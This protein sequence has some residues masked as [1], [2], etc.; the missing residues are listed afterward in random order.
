MSNIIEIW[1]ESL[2]RLL[3]FY[4]TKRGPLM[5]FYPLLFLFFILINLACYWWAMYTAFPELT[6]GG[7][8]QYYAKVQYPVGVLGALFDSLSFFVT[9]FIIRRA[10]NSTKASEYIGHLSI[11]L[12]IA[13]LATF[14]VLFVFTFS[15]WFINYVQATPQSLSG[16]TDRYQQM[17]TD[18]LANP[19][20]NL[21]NIYFG[22]IMGISAMIPTCTHI[23]M[24]LRAVFLQVTGS[25]KQ[26]TDTPLSG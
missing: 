21:R 23:F 26:A 9:I 2:K 20:G 17:A 19:T 6:V 18:A 7:A 10:I 15:G 14:W 13:I 3:H 24:F 25:R 16:R 12:I 4:E 8:G 11:D 5:I 22:L 1:R